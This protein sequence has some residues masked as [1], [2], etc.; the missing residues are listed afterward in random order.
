VHEILELVGVDLSV[1][2]E[3]LDGDACPW[4]PLL[5]I[6]TDVIEHRGGQ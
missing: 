5:Q 3:R 4:H 1:P 2:S 6:A